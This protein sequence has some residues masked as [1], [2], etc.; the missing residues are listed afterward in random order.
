MDFKLEEAL[1]KLLKSQLLQ[2]QFHPQNNR[3]LQLNH[4]QAPVKKK[5]NGLELTNLK[6]H[7]AHSSLLEFAK[8]VIN[9]KDLMS[10]V[11]T[12]KKL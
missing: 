2:H 11:S 9:A 10:I 3:K 6:L 12:S 1:S 7:H 8:M 5:K 4:T